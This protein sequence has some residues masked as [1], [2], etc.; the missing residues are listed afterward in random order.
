ML[1]A[2]PLALPVIVT[3]DGIEGIEAKAGSK[4]IVAASPEG[5]AG[6]ALKGNNLAA[7]VRLA[8][9]SIDGYGPRP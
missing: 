2:M 3:S 7:N 8:L 5:I 4:V 1:D 6:H 9:G